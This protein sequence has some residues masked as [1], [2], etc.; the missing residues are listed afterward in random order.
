MKAALRHLKRHKGRS[1]L[2]LLAVLIPVYTLVFMFGFASAN[3]QDM[4]ETATRLE[5]GHFQVRGVSEHETVST[6]PLIDD[7]SDVL[8]ALDSTDGVEW[9]TVRLDVPA[10]A[11]VGDRSETILVQGVEPDTVARIT[12]IETLIV[13]G[14]YLTSGENGAV[15]G[16]GLA[17][18]LDVRVGGEI[19][20][21][22]VHPDAA[23]GVIKVPVVGI[24]EAPDESMERSLIQVDLSSARSLVRRPTAATAILCMVEDVAGPWDV[25]KI[26]AV[27]AAL[28]AQLP[29]GFEI[30]DWRELAP[31][32]LTYMN[33]MRPVLFIFA[34]SFFVLGALV[35]A[36]TLYL[37]VMERTRELGLILALGASR[38]RVMRMILIEAGLIT[39]AG[40]TYGAL[41]GV[42]LMWIVEAFGGIPLPTRFAEMFRSLGLSGEIHLSVR[43]GDVVISAAI[44]AGVA[45]LA[46]LIPAW[47]AARFEPVEAMRYVE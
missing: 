13:D 20:L 21:L 27:T 30:V 36:N 9:H 34:A 26:D 7:T 5:S 44:M 38:A 31:L 37:S 16:Q 2:T 19:V 40:A 1:L 28:T 18:L 22:G 29:D 12:P 45:L 17:D 46:A 10:L 23:M 25:D 39:A 41:L 14:E 8:S 6:L 24:Y 42:V 11:S 43:A 47:R 33:I 35:V 32:V 15:L 4:F 3:L